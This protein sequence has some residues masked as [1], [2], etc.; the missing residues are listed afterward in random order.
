MPLLVGNIFTRLC[1][2]EPATTNYPYISDDNHRVLK[3]TA[4][5]RASCFH[6]LK[7]KLLNYDVHGR[8]EPAGSPA[9]LTDWNF[10]IFLKF[11]F[12]GPAIHGSFVLNALANNGFRYNGNQRSFGGVFPCDLGCGYMKSWGCMYKS[13]ARLLINY[14]FLLQHVTSSSN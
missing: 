2:R 6:A 4:S 7:I 9:L 14:I 3:K 12:S 1:Q 8:D 5:R 11:M 10:S 13:P